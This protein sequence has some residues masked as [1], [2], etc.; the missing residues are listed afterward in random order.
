MKL[1]LLVLPATGDDFVHFTVSCDCPLVPGTT[2]A[3]VRDHVRDLGMATARTLVD[4]GAVRSEARD[5]AASI[6][7]ELR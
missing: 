6:G 7:I 5:L 1:L 4:R 3:I 2:D